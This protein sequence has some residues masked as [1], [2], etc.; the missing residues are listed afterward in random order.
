MRSTD[1][2]VKTFKKMFTV[3][4]SWDLAEWLQ[5]LIANAEVVTVLG[6]DPSIL[7]HSGIWG[8]ADDAVLNTVHRRKNIQKIPLVTLYYCSYLSVKEKCKNL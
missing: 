6:F 5:R 4:Y 2:N 1:L 8:T 3:H 7:R